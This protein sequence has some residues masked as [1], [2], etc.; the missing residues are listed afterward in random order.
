MVVKE[1]RNQAQLKGAVEVQDLIST[2]NF[3]I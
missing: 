2:L 1:K 3:E